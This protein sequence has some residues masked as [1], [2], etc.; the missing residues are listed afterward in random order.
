MQRHLI[1]QNVVKRLMV[2][3]QF[4]ILYFG[5][6]IGTTVGFLKFDFHNMKI[7]KRFVSKTF[8]C[9]ILL[10]CLNLVQEICFLL[11]MVYICKHLKHSPELFSGAL[12]F[13]GNNVAM[14]LK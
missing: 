7:K 5:L 8:V 9:K 6:L 3:V 12:C 10:S 1:I 11:Y 4:V 13:G 14:P 2:L